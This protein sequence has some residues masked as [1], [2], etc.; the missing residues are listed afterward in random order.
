MPSTATKGF[1]LLDVFVPEILQYVQGCPTIMA[2]THVR[3]SI[4]LFCERS[5]ILK[6][7]PSSFFLTEDVHT[8]TLKYS[9]DR[10]VAIA[11]KE[12]Q[13][14]EGTTGKKLTETTEHELDNSVI[15]WRSME[16]A[17][18]NSYFLTDEINQIRFFEI[19]NQDSD[20]EVYVR[21]IVKPRRNVT[22][23]DEFLWEKWEETIQAGALSSLL[24][25]PGSSWFNG[26]LSNQFSQ[27]FKRGVRRARATSISGT[28]EKPLQ[29]VPRGYEVF[30]TGS[31][32]RRTTLWD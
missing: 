26:Q 9:G 3:N 2:R 28:T 8:Y 6:R 23:V 19:P 5:R 27:E 30:G 10:Y 21:T 25:M 17:E 1:V 32:N 29:V 12:V 31:F 22:E 7:D 20:D 24:M 18:P 13:I 11:S 4:I 14:G 16:G 15:N